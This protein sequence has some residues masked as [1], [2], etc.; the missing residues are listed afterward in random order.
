MQHAIVDDDVEAA[1]IY[2]SKSTV[3]KPVRSHKNHVP[4]IEQEA[5]RPESHFKQP[6]LSKAVPAAGSLATKTKIQGMH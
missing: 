6:V 2:R 4:H 5:T 3:E 1:P